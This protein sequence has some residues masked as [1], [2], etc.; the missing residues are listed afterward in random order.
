V[1]AVGDVLWRP[2]AERVAAAGIT[3]FRDWLAAERD[4]ATADYGELW[5]WSTTDLDGF[6]AAIWDH[7]ELGERPGPVLTDRAL[8]GARW[9]EGARLNFAAAALDRADAEA[10]LIA[11]DEDGGERRIGRERL[12]AEVA[13]AAA[14]LRELGVGRGD[15]VAS[16]LPNCA[17][18]AIAALA[19][20]AVGAVW[21]SCS[22]DIG[23]R[24]VLDRFGQIEPSLLIAAD[25][26]RYGGRVFDRRESV[27][28]VAAGLPG[29]PP[30]A[31]VDGV[32]AGPV[33]GAL[34]WSDAVATH[35]GA[36]LQTEPL[37]F[38]HPLWIL[39]SS[40]TTGLPKAIVHGHGGTVVEQ[41]KAHRLH[42]DLRGGDRFLWFTTTG[43]VAWNL[44]LSALLAG[45][46]PVLY[47]G[48]PNRPDTSR[49]WRVAAQTNATVFGGSPGFWEASRSAGMR[50]R[51]DLGAGSIRTVLSSGAPL[52]PDTA[53]WLVDALGPDVH[54]ADVSGGTDLCSPVVGALPTAPVRAGEIQCRMLGARVEA[55]D[56]AG[57][58]LRD[59]IGELVIAA[60]MP[61]MPLGFA[62]DP[63][64]SRYRAAYFDTYPGVWRH[65]DWIELLP[66]GGCR[67]LGRSDA[68]LNRGG[69]RMGSGE[70][71]PVVERVS[72]VR[73][74]LV[75]DVD[76]RLVLLV[77]TA[78]GELD[79]R[80]AATIRDALRDELSPRHVPDEIHALAALPRT[81]TGGKRLE[82]PVKRIL[83]GVPVEQALS[84]ESVDDAAAVAAIAALAR[85]E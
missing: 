84:V 3:G 40:G 62:G 71:Y 14:A 60:P 67:V 45:A 81:K 25:G 56:E 8:P 58:P 12:R 1:A 78:G 85:G 19:C 27:A 42:L 38:D 22:P 49:L 70:F 66:S 50:P 39:Y 36:P 53:A 16:L 4:V 28:A 31:L 7:H 54:V 48:S 9:F 5:E 72:G 75:V 73:D 55:Y 44:V 15:R 11:V 52:A 23:P 34:S 83:A 68:T 20:A 26:Y 74:S 51:D 65:G 47:D 33:A 35:A 46:T 80:L 30:L 82:V 6:W 77:A 2:G 18:A 41:L 37:P 24:G 32:G 57:R 76:G 17:E 61:S 69:V 43:W 64:G 63:D 10:A 21:S 29:K 59:G 13:A 79:E